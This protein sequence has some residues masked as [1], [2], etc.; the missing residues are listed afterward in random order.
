MKLTTFDNFKAAAI[1]CLSVEDWFR[2]MN[3]K[4]YKM[5]IDRQLSINYI[6]QG[7]TMTYEELKQHID[8]ILEDYYQN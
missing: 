4:D 1:E 6:L 7:T 2:Y 3:N 5:K 8:S